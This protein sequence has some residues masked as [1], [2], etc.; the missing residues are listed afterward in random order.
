MFYIFE[1][2]TSNE[3]FLILESNVISICVDT[4][5][6]VVIE[7]KFT[8]HVGII[9]NRIAD[10]Y[11]AMTCAKSIAKEISEERKTDV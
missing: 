4:D 1:D 6:E 3:V 7:T 2:T 11:S 8:T 5:E 10:F 9:R